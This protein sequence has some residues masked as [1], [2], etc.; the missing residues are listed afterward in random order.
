MT[1]AIDLTSYFERIGYAE[2]SAPTL[3]TL[4]AL[5]LCHTETIPF[6]NLN[7]LVGWPVRLDEES[8]VRKL[9][10]EQRGGYCFEH[11]LL[12]MRVLETI[13]FRVTG[14]AARVLWNAAEGATTM[15]SHMLLRIDCDEE[16]YIADV[17]FG[18]QTLTGPLRLVPDVEQATPH[19][20]FRLI[21]RDGDFVLQSSIQGA[22]KSLY[23][24]DLQPQHAIDYEAA[25]Y[26]L[27]VHPNSIFRTTLRAARPAAGR[28][29][30]LLDNQLAVHVL[31]GATERRALAS[32]AEIRSVLEELFLLRVPESSELDAAIARFL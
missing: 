18:G 15:R 20:P 12:F 2:K 21:E 13:G 29:Y 14:L 19:E 24:F 25:N 32:V 7:P 26:Y 27:S 28:R 22:W 30:A 5:H 8:L 3:E 16:I 4:R 31:N 6:E 1:A 11:N 10:Y 9:V 17:G 23:R